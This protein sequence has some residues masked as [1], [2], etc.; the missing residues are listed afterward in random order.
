MWHILSGS[1]KISRATV[2][3]THSMEEADA[4]CTRISIL[5]NGS[6]QCI[7]SS[8]HIKGRFGSSYSLDLSLSPISAQSEEAAITTTDLL[9]NRLSCYSQSV[10]LVQRLG[11]RLRLRL[12]TESLCLSALF[13]Y[14]HQLLEEDVCVDFSLSQ[15]TLD[16]IFIKFASHQHED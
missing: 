1:G 16:Q 5:V 10:E 12:S 14:I 15:P 3:T 11:R 6:L 9:L 4:L 2:L 13:A 7:G 8:Q